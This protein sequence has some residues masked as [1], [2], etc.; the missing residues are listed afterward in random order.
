[1]TAER[2]EGE[3]AVH[4]G[5]EFTDE[6]RGFVAMQAAQPE[7]VSA[8]M[9]LFSYSAFFLPGIFIGVYAL[10]VQ[11]FQAMAIAFLIMVTN[12]FWSFAGVF[13]EQRLILLTHSVFRKMHAI[14]EARRQR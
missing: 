7:P 3:D 6:E 11:S 12:L 9:R 14:L 10:V 5:P 1:M 2:L 4:S 13:R 8:L